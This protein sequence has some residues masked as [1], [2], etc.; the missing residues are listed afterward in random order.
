MAGG[1]CCRHANDSWTFIDRL[2]VGCHGRGHIGHN[3][4]RCHCWHGWRTLSVYDAAT[5]IELPYTTVVLCVFD[6]T[7]FLAESTLVAEK[8]DEHVFPK[9]AVDTNLFADLRAVRK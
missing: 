1:C 6:L 2:Y 3:H 5:P 7:L 4:C 9:F 8:V